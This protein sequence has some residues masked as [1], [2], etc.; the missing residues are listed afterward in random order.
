[1]V[2]AGPTEDAAARRV[3]AGERPA[4][5]AGWDAE[6][7]ADVDEPARLAVRVQLAEQLG[8]PRGREQLVGRGDLVG[9]PPARVVELLASVDV[10]LVGAEHGVALGLA[11][12]IVEPAE[13]ERARPDPG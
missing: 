5:V 1:M 7:D 3:I 2:I 6:S 8:Q 12:P 10:A 11:P 9:G 13:G 4:C